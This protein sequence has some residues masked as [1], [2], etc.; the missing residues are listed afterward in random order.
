MSTQPA[1]AF[2]QIQ[3]AIVNAVTL[4]VADVCTSVQANRLRPVAAGKNAVVVRI[5][6]ST[7]ADVVT[8]AKDWK[9]LY[10]VECYAHA[11]PGAD[12]LPEAD[13]LVT[14]IAPLLASLSL[15]DLGVIN[16]FASGG[17]RWQFDDANDG[18]VC[19]ML[20]FEVEHRTP[21]NSIAP[22]GTTTPETP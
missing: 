13:V 10:I 4:G 8:C 14:R 19:A 11:R 21:V 3:A 9:T 18:M 17:I 15:P 20:G 7:A 1:S 16:A 2:V 6:Q 12:P 5:E 22:W